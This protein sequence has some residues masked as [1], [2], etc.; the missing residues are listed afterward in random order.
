MNKLAFWN[1]WNTTFKLTFQIL[2]SL[3]LTFVVVFLAIQWGDLSPFYYWKLTGYLEHLS[4]PIFSNHSEFIESTI[5]TDLPLIFQKVFGGS[6]TL[7]ASYSYIYLVLLYGC[8]MGCLTL[9][10]YLEK[11][12]YYIGVGLW[13]LLVALSGIGHVGFF[14]LYNQ[15]AIIVVLLLFLPASYY[16]NSINENI[17]IGS[18]FLVFSGLILIVFGLIYFGSTYESPLLFLARFSYLPAALICLIFI[19]IIGHEIIYAILSLTTPYSKSSSN[20]TTHFIVLS[21]AYLLNLAVLYLYSINYLNWDIYYINEFLLIAISAILGIWG[22]KSRQ[23][24]YAGILPY[25]P[26]TAFLYLGLGIITFV[27]LGFQAFH[28]NDAFITSMQNLILYSHIG[29]GLMF[30]LYIIFNFITQLKQNLPVHQFAYV[31]DNFPYISARIAGL[32]VVAALFF[33][34]HYGSFYQ[35]VAG[36]YNGLGDLNL[37]LDNESIAQYYYKK[38]VSK[39]TNNHHGNFQLALLEKEPLQR[40]LYLKNSIKQEPTA[41]AYA[42]LGREY[43]NSSRFFD[44]LFTYQDGL[45]VFPDH[46]AIQNNMALL[47]SKTNVL[48]SALYYLESSTPGSWKQAVVYANRNAVASLHG[49]ELENQ[50]NIDLGRFDLQSNTLANQLISNDTTSL[51]FVSQP[52]SLALNLFTFGYLK[53]LGLYCYQNQLPEFL[54]LIDPYLEAPENAAFRKELTLVKAFNLYRNGKVSK[55]IE[56]IYQLKEMYEDESGKWNTLLGKWCLELDAPLQA[57]KYLEAAREAYYPNVSADL[58]QAYHRLGDQSLALFL[59]SK[60]SAANDSINPRLA[61]EWTKLFDKMQMNQ[62]VWKRYSFKKERQLLAQAKKG[63][64]DQRLLFERLGLDN[65][66]FE[67]GVLAATNYFQTAEE[68]EMAYRILHEAITVNEFSENLIKAYIDQCLNSGLIDF[69]E[70]ALIKLI[71]ILPREDYEAFEMAYEAKKTK[72]QTQLDQD[73]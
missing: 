8:L 23:N 32:I 33:R 12:W 60:E 22:I 49:L 43:E 59:L 15:T 42:S 45:K 19:L 61:A 69:S 55:A 64:A 58:A 66:F 44:A 68:K 47:Y 46:W 65:P 2:S 17:G 63:G 24:R 73:W 56:L 1:E 54:Q 36:Y 27:T 72:A 4:F 31:E 7:S 67:E 62:S 50:N 6:K 9:S 34:A 39:S 71:D 18:R 35:G 28:G 26:Y 21:V 40:L 53:N 13:I 52:Q 14:D 37:A 29:F 30:F 48:D 57:S 38:S 11:F 3:L 41:Y 25:Y 10:T 51:S 20:N 16:F 5:T 70:D